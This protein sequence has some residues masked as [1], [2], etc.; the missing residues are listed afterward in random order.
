LPRLRQDFAVETK[1]V[2]DL[3]RQRKIT[4]ET[5]L[6]VVIQWRLAGGEKLYNS[7]LWTQSHELSRT[8]QTLAD[9]LRDT[10]ERQMYSFKT[11]PGCIA[12]QKQYHPDFWGKKIRFKALVLCGATQTAKTQKALSFYGPNHTLIVNCQGLGTNLPSL[13]EF[14]R[15]IHKCIVFDEAVSSQ[16]LHNKKVFQ[17]GVEELTLSQ[18]TC[19]I[20]AYKVWLYA[21]PMVLC[22]N[23]FQWKSETKA[24]M[25][26]EDEKYLSENLIDGSLKYEDVWFQAQEA[27]YY[28]DDGV[29][30]F[31]DFD[32]ALAFA[33]DFQA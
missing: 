13:R 9:H 8:Y 28:D 5:V 14:N 17:A 7:V 16:V 6:K 33:E 20:N 32:E 4:H 24:V 2:Y 31:S 30:P 10:H 25:Q 15:E 29:N 21:L 12:W 11:S 22:T 26:P 1:T 27:E 3:W 18:S 19:N 23:H